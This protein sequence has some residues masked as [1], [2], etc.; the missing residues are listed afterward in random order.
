VLVQGRRS[1]DW[2]GAG[3]GAQQRARAGA[4]RAGAEIE[5]GG[6]RVGAGH[7]LN[8]APWIE[9]QRRHRRA[10]SREKARRPGRTS[11]SRAPWA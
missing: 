10:A 8:R 4:H 6:R 5:Q 7:E 2:L 9:E 3:A 1:S 11:G